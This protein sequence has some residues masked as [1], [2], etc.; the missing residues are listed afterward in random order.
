MNPTKGIP[1]NDDYLDHLG[2]PE[3]VL[4][5]APHP[6]ADLAA[7]FALGFAIGLLLVVLCVALS[8][9]TA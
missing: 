4:P 8:W 5:S 6:L 1:V 2:E 3:P 9:W 7:D